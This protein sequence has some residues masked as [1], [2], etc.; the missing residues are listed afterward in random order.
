MPDHTPSPQIVAAR[1]VQ[2]GSDVTRQVKRLM[3]LIDA[4]E[5]PFRDLSRAV[6]GWR[7]KPIPPGTLSKVQSTGK[8]LYDI[9]DLQFEN[10]D[11]AKRLSKYVR[12]IKN[13]RK[14]IGEFAGASS[15]EEL[16]EVYAK[17]SGKSKNAWNK[18]REYKNDLLGLMSTFDSEPAGQFRL[19]GMN[20]ALIRTGSRGFTPE[21]IEKVKAVLTKSERFLQQR[22]LGDLTKG[23]TV[24]VFPTAGIPGIP[25]AN[26]W[27]NRTND[28]AAIAAGSAW[29]KKSSVDRMVQ[30]MVH[31][32]GHRAYYRLMGSRS[33]RSWEAFYEDMQQPPDVD[34]MIRDWDA[35]VAEGY[36]EKDKR[37]RSHFREWHRKLN[38]EDREA[39]T[40][41]LMVVTNFDLDSGEKL[42]SRH[43]LPTKSSV[44][45]LDV[46]KARK[47]EIKV[48]SEPVTAYS[49][50]NPSELFAEAFAHY[51]SYGPQ[52]LSPRLRAEFR[53]ALPKMKMARTGLDWNQHV[54][55][56]R[57]QV[58]QLRNLRT[59]YRNQ[60]RDIRR[61]VKALDKMLSRSPMYEYIRRGL[62][63]AVLDLD[64]DDPR[65]T[66]FLNQLDYLTGQYDKI[67]MASKSRPSAPRVALRFA[68]GRKASTRKTAAPFV[69]E[70]MVG[71]DWGSSA[72][73]LLVTDGDRVLLLK[74][75]P[76]V[77]DPGLWGIPGGAVPVDY[78][79]GKRKDAKRSAL[80]EAR[81]EMGGI[82][83]GS[84]GGKHVFRKPSGFTFTTYIYETDPDSLDRFT[85]R[86][87]WEHTDWGLFDLDDIKPSGIHPGVIWVLNRMGR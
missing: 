62:S 81:E 78:D 10:P 38:G 13:L 4:F 2:A 74:R 68:S 36:D 20:V 12:R 48:F 29:F 21:I 49:S 72:S 82:P 45:A 39:A 60:I 83:S 5:D 30:T 42:D 76:Y 3:D 27:Y 37:K 84:V 9:L 14:M 7:P 67:R 28:T 17:H 1:H 32:L 55:G 6:G 57:Q 26:A 87:N 63:R 34:G 54:S 75:S 33:R 40:W 66:S 71:E 46:L 77:Q 80:D 79:T 56:L 31:E 35:F 51:L 64:G 50:T 8:A 22:G 18:L 59:D 19:G 53:K 65:T 25:S 85:P 69:D 61:A 58:E 24:F 15:D 16:S 11:Q 70:G 43:G 23:L 86:L 52:T 73:G 47:S 41:L 44:P